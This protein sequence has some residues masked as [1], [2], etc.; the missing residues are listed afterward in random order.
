VAEGVMSEVAA[1]LQ[2]AHRA[3]RCARKRT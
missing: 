2:C 1:R 3:E